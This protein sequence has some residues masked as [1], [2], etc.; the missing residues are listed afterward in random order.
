MYTTE[1]LCCVVHFLW[2]K[3]L[4][5]K[6]DHKEMLPVYIGKCLLHKVVYNLIEKFSQDCSKVADDARPGHPVDVATE[7]T[8]RQL[9]ELIRAD[10]RMTVD[11]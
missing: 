2:A 7:A 4:S 6:D 11:S 8:V 3:G 5:P 10:R 9:K 1:V